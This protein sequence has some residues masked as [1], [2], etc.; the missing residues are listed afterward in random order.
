MYNIW[1]E[2]K[3]TEKLLQLHWGPD[4]WNILATSHHKNIVRK[5]DLGIHWTWRARSNTNICFCHQITSVCEMFYIVI[6]SLSI[7]QLTVMRN[8]NEILYMGQ[9]FSILGLLALWALQITINVATSKPQHITLAET[10][11][12]LPETITKYVQRS[13]PLTRQ[14]PAG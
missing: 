9:Y 6:M 10:D 13:S 2:I 12:Q 3:L 14:T 1:A 4:G 11:E 7:N 5:G 8:A